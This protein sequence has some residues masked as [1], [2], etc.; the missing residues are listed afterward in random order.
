MN[1]YNF[2][3]CYFYKKNGT[4]IGGR[5][6]GSGLV[7]FSLLIHL[8]FFSELIRDISGYKFI[9]FPEQYGLTYN[10]RKIRYIFIC[11]PIIVGF[12]FFYNNERVKRIL[13]KFDNRDEYVQQ[14]DTNRVI[15]YI[16]VPALL[17][18]I[19]TLIRQGGFAK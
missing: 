16:I 19:L 4:H 5:I 7:V 6:Y 8:Y 2:I 17:T 14:G 18:L 12:Y 11:I 13:E 3:F 1:I 10:Q 9:I 15:L